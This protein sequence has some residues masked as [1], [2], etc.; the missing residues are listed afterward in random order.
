SDVC[1]I[2]SA[3]SRRTTPLWR[4]GES[5]NES[6]YAYSGDGFQKCSAEGERDDRGAP[7][8]WLHDRDRYR[9]PYR[10]LDLCKGP[11]GPRSIFLGWARQLDQHLRRWA[12]HDRF[13]SGAGHAAWG[14]ES[15]RFA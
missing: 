7:W 2:L 14:Q 1:V 9:G 8:T 12:R 10:Q 4:C 11:Y 6:R 15:A 5:L 3:A 13:R